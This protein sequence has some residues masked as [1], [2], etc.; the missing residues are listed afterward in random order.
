MLGHSL[1]PPPWQ[2]LGLLGLPGRFLIRGLAGVEEVPG[3]S[4]ENVNVGV[5]AKLKCR[6][7]SRLLTAPVLSLLISTV[8]VNSDLCAPPCQLKILTCSVQSLKHS[9]EN[10]FPLDLELPWG[11]AHGTAGRVAKPHRPEQA[12]PLGRRGYKVPVLVKLDD[13]LIRAQETS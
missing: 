7:F 11:C 10:D 4:G 5:R 3:S 1:P 2:P 9:C 13:C 12:S 8:G 6:L